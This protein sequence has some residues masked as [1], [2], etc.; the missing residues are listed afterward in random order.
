MKLSLAL[1]ALTANSASARTN[2]IIIQP[3]DMACKSYILCSHT[4]LYDISLHISYLLYILIIFSLSI[5]YILSS[6]VYEDWDP[7]AHLPTD[8]DYP[9]EIYPSGSNLP[10]I[11]KLR[12]DG[13]TM[14]NAYA[15]SPKCGTSRYST[16]TGRYASR[17]ATARRAAMQN[18]IFPVTVTIPR[19]KLEDRGAVQDGQDCSHSNIAQVFS[20]NHYVTGM[21]GKWHLTDSGGKKKREGYTC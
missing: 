6:T 9:G 21:V 2:F 5:L 12:G 7:P 8:G 14:T 16:V 4:C 11:N 3:D 13:M 15:T 20:S 17:S 18:N 10:W 1:A 19:A